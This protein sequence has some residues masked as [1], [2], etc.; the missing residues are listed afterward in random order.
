[1]KSWYR[2]VEIFLLTIIA[3]TLIIGQW[4]TTPEPEHET[5]EGIINLVQW[6]KTVGG[7]NH[8]YGV[9]DR[10]LYWEQ[11]KDTA[12]QTILNG[13]SG[14][15][16]TITSPIENDFIRNRVITQTHQPSILDAFWLGG[17]LSDSGWQWITGEPFGFENWSLYEP[18]NIKDETALSMW[19]PSNCGDRYRPG[20]WNNFLPN[21]TIN[22]LHRIWSIVE[23][24]A[25][26]MN[27]SP[28]ANDTLIHLVRW[29]RGNGG[30]NH[31]YGIIALDLYHDDARVLASSLK[32]DGVNGHL[33][34]IS[35]AEENSFILSQV[36]RD[37]RQPSPLDEYWLGG[38]YV[39]NNWTWTDDSKWQFE[40][41]APREPNNMGKET[42]VSMWGNFAYEKS[43]IAGSWNNCL[44]NNQVNPLAHFY[45]IIEFD[46]PIQD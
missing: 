32:K 36:I 43:R 42:A 5:P 44:P 30:N 2:I 8:W 40:N 46:T 10:E 39:S 26:D 24:G 9:I 7:N 38:T 21:G 20:Q 4:S 31:W 15:L 11:A 12:R 41:W 23:W 27:A 16:A 6:S 45:S 28:E 37:Y 33:A 29:T 34:T 1:M 13:K 22:R 19:G 18:N 35:T 17:I 3:I 14:Y 25:N